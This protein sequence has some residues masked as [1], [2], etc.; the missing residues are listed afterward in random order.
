MII[1]IS[2]LFLSSIFTTAQCATSLL[3]TTAGKYFCVQG[4][5]VVVSTKTDKTCYLAHFSIHAHEGGLVLNFKY[6]SACKYMCINRCGEL[7]YDEMYHI[8]DCKFTTMAFKE[9]DSLSVNRGNYSDFIAFADYNAL[10]YSLKDGDVLGRGETYLKMSLEKSGG[11]E[12]ILGNVDKNTKIT[13]KCIV[14]QNFDSTPFDRHSNY[15]FSLWEK[16]LIMINW[17]RIEEPKSDGLRKIDYNK[18]YNAE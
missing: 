6:E 17:F 1:P 10:L 16:F 9:F 11:A 12:C 15:N 7:Y 8:E 4:S 13:K 3:K 5:N 18:N 14:K 2:L